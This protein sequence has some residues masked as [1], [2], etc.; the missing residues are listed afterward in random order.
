LEEPLGHGGMGVVW[1][2]SSVDGQAVAI[3]F[4]R[5]ADD[6]PKLRRRFVRE[7]RAAAAIEHPKRRPRVLEVL[8]LEGESPRS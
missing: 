8:E 4:M 2:A 5:G 3:K 1:A 6:D 7:A